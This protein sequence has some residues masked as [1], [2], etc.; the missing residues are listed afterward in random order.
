LESR[1][2]TALTRVSKQRQIE[3]RHGT[4]AKAALRFVAA[5]PNPP[6]ASFDENDKRFSAC[7][8]RTA[9]RRFT[10]KATARFRPQKHVNR[11]IKSLL[12]VAIVLTNATTAFCYGANHYFRRGFAEQKRS[13]FDGA[14]ADYTKAIQLKPH[15]V[16]AYYDRG[17]SKKAKG[18]LDG[19]IADYS[20]VIELKPRYAYAYCTRQ[21]VL[22]HFGLSR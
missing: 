12:L 10:K 5:D 14:I 7:D 21:N 8:I 13:D 3:G 2:P 20:K 15:F 11:S 16:Y 17:L 22:G 1:Q 9:S 6:H 19:A 4:Q 18:D